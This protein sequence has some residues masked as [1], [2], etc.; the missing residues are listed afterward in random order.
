MTQRTREQAY[1]DARR[2]RHARVRALVE[3]GHDPRSLQS[4]GLL[5]E[6]GTIPYADIVMNEETAEV[7]GRDLSFRELDFNDRSDVD[8][9]TWR[10][11]E[12]FN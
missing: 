7:E 1:A 11:I 12:E 5:T 9:S 6:Y 3:R 2:A 10:E 8:W 4:S